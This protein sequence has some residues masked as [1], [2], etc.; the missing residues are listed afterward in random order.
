MR[1]LLGA[2]SLLMSVALVNASP[3]DDPLAS[4]MWKDMV[5]RLL[6][7][8]TVVFD[9]RIKVVVPSVVED[10]AQVPVTADARALAN[11]EKLLVFA[12][13]NPIQHILTLK[14]DKA[15]AYVSFRMKV[16]QGT[17]IRAAALTSDG[18]WHVGGVY[19]DAAGGGCSAPAAAREKPNW[20]LSLGETHG[21]MWRT[22]DGTTRARF[23][24]RHPMD[25]GLTRDG[26]PAYYMERIALSDDAGDRLATLEMFEPVSED[27]TLTVHV[28][29]ADRAAAIH[30]EGRDTG[31]QIYKSRIEG[32]ER[33]SEAAA[34]SGGSSSQ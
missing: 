27:P 28:R 22:I 11:V 15:D 9:D 24:I 14:P 26:I 10:Q 3:P 13:L 25:T 1:I 32:S 34:P 30:L 31:G 29:L 23:K 19:L 7:D 8:G 12:D 33:R 6:G 21:Q 20:H 18:V 17:P 16:E 4:P 5:Q 2:L